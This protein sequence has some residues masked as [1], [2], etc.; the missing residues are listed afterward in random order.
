MGCGFMIMGGIEIMAANYA[1]LE[2][3][4]QY[5]DSRDIPAENII[6]AVICGKNVGVSSILLLLQV[7]STSFCP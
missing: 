6:F 2:S 5:I 3:M 4:I 7:G 1:I